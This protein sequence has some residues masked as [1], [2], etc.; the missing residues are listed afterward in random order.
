MLDTTNIDPELLEMFSY[1][2]PTSSHQ[3]GAIIEAV[4]FL[5][6]ESEDLLIV[7]KE[8]I[9]QFGE[10]YDFDKRYIY[11]SNYYIGKTEVSDTNEIL[12]KMMKL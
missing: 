4:G 3:S 11:K 2:I 9:V 5:P 1:R 8:H 7:P 12:L 6:R 10:D